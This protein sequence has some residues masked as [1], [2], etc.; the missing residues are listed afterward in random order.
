MIITMTKDRPMTDEKLSTSSPLQSS[1]ALAFEHLAGALQILAEAV[2]ARM[3]VRQVLAFTIIA[4]ANAMG[5][6]ITLTEVREIAGEGLGQSI[7][8]TIQ[9]F[10]APTKR[11]PDALGWLEQVPDE[12][13]RRKKYLVLTE[14]GRFIVNEMTKALALQ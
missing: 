12:D 7:E 10:L 3:S 9:G 8:R 13:D 11:E 2:P 5:R 6:S 1:S 4:Y 14:R